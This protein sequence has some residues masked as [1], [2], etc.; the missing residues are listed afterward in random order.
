MLRKN[1][2]TYTKP[3]KKK[4]GVEAHTFNISTWEAEAGD[5]CESEAS[6]IY[7][8]SVRTATM[9]TQRTLPQ[10]ITTKNKQQQQQSKQEILDRVMIRHL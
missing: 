6:L 9:V 4:Q 5:L 10:T 2:I 3:V 8:A 1:K 7:K